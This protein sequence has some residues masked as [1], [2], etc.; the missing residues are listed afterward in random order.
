MNKIIVENQ[1]IIQGPKID[2]GPFFFIQIID[3]GD[4]KK[5]KIFGNPKIG[6]AKK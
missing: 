3:I 6:K 5:K 1:G 4:A 2:I